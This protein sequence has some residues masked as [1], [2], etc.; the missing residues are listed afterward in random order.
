MEI[1]IAQFLSK[2]IIED[3]ASVCK[4]YLKFHMHMD[5]FRMP[6]TSSVLEPKFNK[7]LTASDLH[8][9]L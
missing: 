7:K 1:K 8:P 9:M 3:A 5:E 4:R 6:E 2:N